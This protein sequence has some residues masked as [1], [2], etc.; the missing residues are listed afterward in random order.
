MF[1]VRLEFAKRCC[2]NF[3]LIYPSA[4][5]CLVVVKEENFYSTQFSQTIGYNISHSYWKI[6]P[7][8]SFLGKFKFSFFSIFNLNP[9]IMI[10]KSPKHLLN[11]WWN[12]ETYYLKM[13]NCLTS[14][15]KQ[16]FLT[17]SFIF[18]S[19][20]LGQSKKGIILS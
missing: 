10:T 16:F 9:V 13:L 18:H 6:L 5:L 12:G 20:G 1:K 8:I 4:T 11:A 7:K 2:E 3:L 17:E 19:A 15:S 14:D